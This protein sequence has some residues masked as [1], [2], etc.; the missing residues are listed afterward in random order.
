MINIDCYNG[1]HKLCT[2]SDCNCK[3]HEAIIGRYQVSVVHFP[4]KKK[5]MELIIDKPRE[6][7]PEVRKAN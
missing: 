2:S 1:H 4:R 7:K 3:C 5:K 6:I